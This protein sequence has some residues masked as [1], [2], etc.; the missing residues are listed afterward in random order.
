MRPVQSPTTKKHFSP[1]GLKSNTTIRLA[2]T[3]CSSGFSLLGSS[4]FSRRRLNLKNGRLVFSSA[5]RVSR[6][7][8]DGSPQEDY[9]ACKPEQVKH[10][11]ENPLGP[12][13]SSRPYLRPN[14][15]WRSPASKSGSIKTLILKLQ[16]HTNKNKEGEKKG[17][18]E[19]TR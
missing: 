15:R 2:H 6:M 19:W 9:R 11:T 13:G 3:T 7:V 10:K 4:P 18:K 17:T 14:P 12:L 1:E 8:L 16:K 5:S